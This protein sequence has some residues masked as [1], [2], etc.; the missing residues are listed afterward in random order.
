M[1][2]CGTFSVV[3]ENRPSSFGMLAKGACQTPCL[4]PL[5]DGG[6]GHHRRR[7]AWPAATAAIMPALLAI[8][9]RVTSLRGSS[10][11]CSSR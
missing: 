10:L 3:H 4:M 11:L 6:L 9:I 8:S 2:F 5:R 7:S 1:S